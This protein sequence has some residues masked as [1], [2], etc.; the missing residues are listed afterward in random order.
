MESRSG[1]KSVK[2]AVQ[3]GRTSKAAALFVGAASQR[4]CQLE[5]SEH[6]VR[7]KEKTQARRAALAETA[8]RAEQSQP[9][10][11]N[12]QCPPEL[13]WLEG[14]QLWRYLAKGK[15][16]SRPRAASDSLDLSESTGAANTT[17]S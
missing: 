2:R 3:V 16:G 8:T 9:R 17:A 13:R 14:V 1:E 10:Q 11:E 6:L 4:D 5:K 7:K 15:T 12:T